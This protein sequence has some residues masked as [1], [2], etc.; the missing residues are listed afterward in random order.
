MADTNAPT[1]HNPRTRHA[2][3]RLITLPKGK[4]TM[5]ATCANTAQR[6]IYK[7]QTHPG[8][9]EHDG[10]KQRENQNHQPT[11]KQST[12]SNEHNSE[13]VPNIAV[14]GPQS[15]PLLCLNV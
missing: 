11:A 5:R 4:Q 7:N 14:H 9:I 10:F 15:N 12:T 6:T 8:E 2:R 13:L 3:K 1:N